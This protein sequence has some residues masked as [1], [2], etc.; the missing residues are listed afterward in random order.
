MAPAARRAAPS[1]VQRAMPSP[2]SWIAVVSRSRSSVSDD[3][4]DGAVEDL[5]DFR[6]GGGESALGVG[7]V[8]VLVLSLG[9]SG[10]SGL[11]SGGLG[12][13]TDTDCEGRE[14]R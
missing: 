1:A 5:E 7:A 3:A 12:A 11:G 13:G 14:E 9:G 10:S 4:E 6:E 2:T 8:G